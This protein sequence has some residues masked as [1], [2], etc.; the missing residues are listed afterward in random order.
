MIDI[1]YFETGENEKL[2]LKNIEKI[3]PILHFPKKRKYKKTLVY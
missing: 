3:K 2:Y 1:N